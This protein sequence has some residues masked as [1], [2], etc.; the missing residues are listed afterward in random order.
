MTKI[1]EV[2]KQRA[3]GRQ[4]RGEQVL[5]FRLLVSAVVGSLWR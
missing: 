3:V 4:S 2:T 1:L 5:D